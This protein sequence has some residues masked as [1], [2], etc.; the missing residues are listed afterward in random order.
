MYTV[1]IH[2]KHFLIG[3]SQTR[4]CWRTF[5]E[6]YASRRVV[7]PG[8]GRSQVPFASNLMALLISPLYHRRDHHKV[9]IHPLNRLSLGLFEFPATR[10]STS[11][12]LSGYLL[13]MQFPHLSTTV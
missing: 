4:V 5:N 13:Y 2:R 8:S 10:K 1:L 12:H 11:A 6:H 9:V 3:C 7:K